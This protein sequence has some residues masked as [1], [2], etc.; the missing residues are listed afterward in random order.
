[1]MGACMKK[2]LLLTLLLPS[3]TYAI[4]PLNGTN[5]KTIDDKTNQATAIVQFNE[6]KNGNLT[7][8]IKKVLV[9]GEEDVCKSCVGEFKNK[10]LKELVIVTS[11][12]K[13]G[14]NEY[15]NG[16][17]LDPDTDKVYRFNARIESNGKKLIG[18]GYVGLSLIG[19]NQ[20]WYR[21]N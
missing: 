14:E 12:K 18:R 13:V 21:V 15:E 1:M 2:L 10:S 4:D 6:D 3:L 19:R 16:K 20:I 8:K 11:L 9:P 7:A 5:W 17:I